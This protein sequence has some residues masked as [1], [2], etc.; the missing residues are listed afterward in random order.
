MYTLNIDPG[1]DAD[2]IQHTLKQNV[3]VAKSVTTGNNKLHLPND[4]GTN[5]GWLS[6]APLENNAITWET[7]YTVY[8]SDTAI[9]EGNVISQ[10]SSW[11]GN[12]DSC[13]YYDFNGA[14]FTRGADV[15]PCSGG[16]Y[17][18]NKDTNPYTF[19]I[20]QENSHS[21]ESVYPLIAITVGGGESASFTP[22]EMASV[23]LSAYKDSGTVITSVWS[24]PCTV[25]LKDG[26]PY[27]LLFDKATSSFYPKP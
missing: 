1:D 19:G 23:F 6:F 12:A 20:S 25:T 13:V 5:V 26:E 9:Q 18:H 14:K 22:V 27:T 24:N 16:Y 21:A 8:A 17:I 2:Y 7:Y 10:E 3:I 15:D 4:Q 11:R